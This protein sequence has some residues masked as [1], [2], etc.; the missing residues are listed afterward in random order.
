MDHSSPNIFPSCRDV[1]KEQAGVRRLGVIGLKQTAL[2]A[3][4]LCPVSSGVDKVDFIMTS[5]AQ[6]VG[7]GQEI[8]MLHTSF[9]GSFRSLTCDQRC[10]LKHNAQWFMF[11]SSHYQHK[12]PLNGN[13]MNVNVYDS[14][15]ERSLS[16]LAR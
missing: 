1:L 7:C 4:T 16:L 5:P 6:P 8:N 13:V 10:Q 2:V 14:F 3:H 15:V 12:Q 9:S 11:P